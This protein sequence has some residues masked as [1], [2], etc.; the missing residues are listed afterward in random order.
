MK[1]N[2]FVNAIL[3]FFFFSVVILVAVAVSTI[4]LTRKVNDYRKQSQQKVSA[5][6][7]KETVPVLVATAGIVK[8]VNIK[9]GQE[10]N[11][12]DILVVMDNPSLR[13]KIKALENYPENVSAQ[14]EAQVAKSQVDA[15]KVMAP[16]SGIVGEVTV[17][18]G[19]PVQ[20]LSP[21]ASIYA[22]SGALLLA[23][24]TSEQYQQARKKV[25]IKAF[26]P[27]LNQSFSV[28]PAFLDPKVEEPKEKLDP[29]KIGLYFRLLDPEH[30][31]SLL[32]N[33]DL[34]LLI[35]VEQAKISKPV[36]YFVDFWNKVFS[37]EDSA[38]GLN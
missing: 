25:E 22:N 6:V 4:G 23:H 33:E 15:F 3:N 9:P 21:I 29:K 11:Q 5:T 35:E 26:S 14:T 13:G 19:T 37:V 10:V 18:Q 8:S 30:A 28:T 1:T 32:Q 20:D 36:D 2:A 12:G 7:I 24:L 27:R 31:S 38:K 16:A 17:T 34:E